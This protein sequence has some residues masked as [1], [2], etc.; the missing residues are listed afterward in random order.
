MAAYQIAG[1]TCVQVFFVRGGNNN[2]NRAFFP[3]HTQDQSPED[4]LAAFLVQFYEDKVPPRE[5]MRYSAR[6]VRLP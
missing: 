6:G 3:T 5:V 1:Q 2:G 4:V